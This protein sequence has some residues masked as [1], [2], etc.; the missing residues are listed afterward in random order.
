[1]CSTVTGRLLPITA[2][3][4]CQSLLETHL[5]LPRFRHRGATYLVYLQTLTQSSFTFYRKMLRKC[6]S[7]DTFPTGF[8]NGSP[9]SV[10]NWISIMRINGSSRVSVINCRR[11][12]DEDW[13]QSGASGTDWKAKETIHT[14]MVSCLFLY[15]YLVYS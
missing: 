11:S 1:M 6:L 8:T 4:V 15:I 9:V 3:H 10:F 2:M 5:T 7:S 13:R 14:L 12:L